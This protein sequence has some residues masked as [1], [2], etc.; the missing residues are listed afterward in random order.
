ME[1]SDLQN[2]WWQKWDNDVER[3]IVLRYWDTHSTEAPRRDNLRSVLHSEMD[4]LPR[5]LSLVDFGCGNGL[6]AQFLVGLGVDYT[7]ADVTPAML[8]EARKAHPGLRFEQDDIFK[9]KFDDESFDVV[10]NSA[11]LPHLPEDQIPI[12]ISELW[13]ITK[14]LLIVRLFGVR[15]PGGDSQ[16][17]VERGFIYQRWPQ[18]K[19]V[20]LFEKHACAPRCHRGDT[21]QTADC[22]ILCCD[23]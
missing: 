16:Y 8:E 21:D 20:G 4:P 15:V 7:G 17:A 18:E 14:K 12:A 10:L 23:K 6:D 5:P 13:R 19:W 11:V 1:P 22:L 9:S 2:R 3:N